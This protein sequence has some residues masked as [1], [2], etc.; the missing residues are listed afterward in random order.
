MYERIEAELKG[1]QKFVYS[2]CAVSI[3]PPSSEVTELGDEPAQ[4]Q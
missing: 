4:L 3:V 1:V 2:S